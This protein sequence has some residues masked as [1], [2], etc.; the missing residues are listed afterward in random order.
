MILYLWVVCL[1]HE[2]MHHIVTTR[3]P[4]TARIRRRP[5]RRRRSGKKAPKL[6]QTGL[7]GI[8][9]VVI[10]ISQFYY[11][12]KLHTPHNGRVIIN[13]QH[14]PQQPPPSLQSICP[15]ESVLLFYGISDNLLMYPHNFIIFGV[16]SGWACTV[17]STGVT[18]FCVSVCL[19]F[20]KWLN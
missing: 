2:D 9:S 11:P 6:W 15:I 7:N 8:I 16:L 19:G 14:P 12:L 13:L 1:C 3:T 10:G 4:T 18:L 20:D 17:L 5:R